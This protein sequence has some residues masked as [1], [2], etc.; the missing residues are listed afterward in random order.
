VNDRRE[1]GD[2]VGHHKLVMED[3]LPTDAVL[4]LRPPGH[5]YDLVA[6]RK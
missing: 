4:T 5:V 6:G 3:G 1:Y 2:Y